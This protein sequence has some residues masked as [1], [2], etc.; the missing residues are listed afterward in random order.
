MKSALYGGLIV[1]V[2]A[3]ILGCKETTSSEFI[4]TGGMAALID[5]TA[6]SA[7]SAKVHVELRV[8]GPNSN[9]F[10][11][12]RNGDTLSA[13]D[14]TESKQLVAVTDGVYEGTFATGKEVPFTVSL[15]R[16]DDTDAPSSKGTLPPPFSITAPAESAVVSR[17]KEDLIVLW[18]KIDAADGTLSVD[19]PCLFLGKDYDINPS[20]GSY[21]IPRGDLESFD[22]KKPESCTAT[23][24]VKIRRA[25]TP[26]PNFD[27]DSYFNTYQKRSMTFTSAP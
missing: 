1:A 13:K 9:T 19:G 16:T 23:L 2:A 3:G 10:V 6:E 15:N 26:D 7:D 21:T 12:L 4:K 17:S 25:G 8:G 22:D 20:S 14:D 18:D 24:D 27:P 11:I 5:V